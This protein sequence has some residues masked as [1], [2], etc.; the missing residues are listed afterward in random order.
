MTNARNCA[1]QPSPS[2]DLVNWH[3][4]GS[5]IFKP[6]EDDLEKDPS[7]LEAAVAQRAIKSQI[8]SVPFECYQ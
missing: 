3:T 5:E 6:L 2:P 4:L 7:F 1:P 8:L